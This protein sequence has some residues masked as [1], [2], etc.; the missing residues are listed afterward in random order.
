VVQYSPLFFF[1]MTKEVL[2][3]FES[4][5]K[6]IFEETKDIYVKDS[7]IDYLCFSGP[8]AKI[9][10]PKNSFLE[11]F[12]GTIFKRCMIKKIYSTRF[13]GDIRI[14]GNLGLKYSF[15]VEDELGS[16][17]EKVL[18]S[19]NIR[20][21]NYYEIAD[22]M[23]RNFGARKIIVFAFGQKEKAL[24]TDDIISLFNIYGPLEIAYAAHVVH[25]DPGL[26]N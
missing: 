24:T 1:L 6:F 19:S 23:T 17:V 4:E 5:K 8:V 20:N 25:R 11:N 21:A 7:D 10:G 14:I 15:G 22:F 26:N 9:F 18:E 3:N 13:K 2:A 12:M 16:D